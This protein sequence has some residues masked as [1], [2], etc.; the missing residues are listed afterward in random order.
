MKNKILLVLF[1]VLLMILS[2]CE[3]VS[4]TSNLENH[5]TSSLVT[6]STAATTMQSYTVESDQIATQNTEKEAI[7]ETTI[8]FID[9][10]LP[11]SDHMDDFESFMEF[12]IDRFTGELYHEKSKL[13]PNHIKGDGAIRFIVEGIEMHTETVTTYRVRVLEIYGWEEELDTEKVYLLGY[14]GTPK[15]PLH[16]RPALE[17]GKEYLRLKKIDLSLDVI[18]MTMAL[19][20]AY[21]TTGKAYVYG[22]GFDFSQLACAIEIIDE[23]ENQIFKPGI[24]T[25][26]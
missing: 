21:T 11:I 1:V 4:E 25:Q 7:T 16:D 23:T 15:N 6:D 9:S 14:R 22:Y 24:H 19:P 12:P 26:S 13:V 5:G 8:A 17:I 18:Q 3:N 2:S 20:L 10:E